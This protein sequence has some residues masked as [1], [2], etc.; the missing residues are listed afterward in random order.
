VFTDYTDLH[1]L[2]TRPLVHSTIW[3]TASGNVVNHTDDVSSPQEFFNKVRADETRA[4]GDKEGH[5]E[6][7]VEVETEVEG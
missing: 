7:R 6:V 2:E 4:A 1:R 3:G 5:G